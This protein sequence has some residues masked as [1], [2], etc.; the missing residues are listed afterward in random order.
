MSAGK[1]ET[2]EKKQSDWNSV[3]ENVNIVDDA[4][5]QSVAD[6]PR[7]PRT[8][9]VQPTVPAA[10]CNVQTPRISTHN[11]RNQAVCTMQ[12]TIELT[13]QLPKVRGNDTPG[14]AN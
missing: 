7:E 2:C 10:V 9:P 5:T 13:P 1:Y 14:M 3:N 4:G 11:G 12:T 6:R 8:L